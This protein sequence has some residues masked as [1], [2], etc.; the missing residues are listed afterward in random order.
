MSRK[1]ISKEGFFIS[2]R[3]LCLFLCISP[4]AAL[5]FAYLMSTEAAPQWFQAIGSIA[6]ILVAV[7]ISKQ[8]GR[9][10]Q[11]ELAQE[12]IRR[13]KN[14]LSLSRATSKVL[15]DIV[16]RAHQVNEDPLRDPV[17]REDFIRTLKIMLNGK[18]KALQAV[19]LISVASSDFADKFTLFFSSLELS[20][21]FAANILSDESATKNIQALREWGGE[22]DKYILAMD[23]IL[24]RHSKQHGFANLQASL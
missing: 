6:A 24:A 23:T 4:P 21:A 10:R 20:S 19:D 14:I 17:M 11:R 22:S 1:T 8:E 12:E 5:F 2:W 9:R 16:N 3:N 7:W 15:K 13:M 18:V